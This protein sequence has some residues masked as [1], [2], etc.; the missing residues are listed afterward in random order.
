MPDG[1]SREELKGQWLTK[2]NAH[3]NHELHGKG[4]TKNLEYL[5]MQTQ[6]PFAK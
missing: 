1:Q 3:L 6:W 2:V 5:Q 4:L